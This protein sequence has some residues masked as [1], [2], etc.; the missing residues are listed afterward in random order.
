M[1]SVLNILSITLFIL[2]FLIKQCSDAFIVAQESHH[3]LKSTII[4][5]N[6]V[7]SVVL[8][9]NHQRCTLRTYQSLTPHVIAAAI[10]EGTG[11]EVKLISRNTFGQEVCPLQYCL[12]FLSRDRVFSEG[13][14]CVSTQQV[15]EAHTLWMGMSKARHF[16]V[17]KKVYSV[18]TLVQTDSNPTQTANIQNLLIN[19]FVSLIE[20]MC[21]L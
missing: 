1:K 15:W 21:P 10:F 4:K 12:H 16:S 19:W 9:V 20:V 7:V 3:Q 6:G 14:E 11:M 2:V 17:H 13:R 5:V 8:D 18:V